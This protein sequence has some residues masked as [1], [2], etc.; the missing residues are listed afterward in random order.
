[1]ISAQQRQV[2]VDLGTRSYDILIGPDLLATAGTR[3]AERL[4]KARAAIVTDENV[5]AAHAATLSASLEQAGIEAATITVAPGEKS[6]NFATLER[7]VDEVIEIGRA[8]CR[9]NG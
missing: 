9:E 7:V 5:A 8:S 3:I 1:M 4:P 2:R 6:K